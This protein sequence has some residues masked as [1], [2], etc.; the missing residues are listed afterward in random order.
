MDNDI[1]RASLLI[2]KTEEALLRLYST[3]ELHGTVHTC[4]GQELTG[5]I[6]CKF[7]KKNDWVFSNHRCHGHFL[8][9]TDDVTGLI[10]EVMGKETG[11]CGGRGGSQH[12]CKGGF[13]F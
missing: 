10:A 9:R 3:G 7:L 11:V 5:V 13:F 2:R 12:L 6:V 8:S 1:L 4:I